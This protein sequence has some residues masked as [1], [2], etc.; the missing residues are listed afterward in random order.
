MHSSEG[1]TQNARVIQSIFDFYVLPA[2]QME[3]SIWLDRDHHIHLGG[4]VPLEL[5]KEW[6]ENGLISDSQIL[7]DLHAAHFGQSISTKDALLKYRK[8][9]SLVEAYQAHYD[10]LEDF[11]TLFRA[12]APQEL[13]RAN[14]ARIMKSIAPRAD[15]RISVPKPQGDPD[16]WAQK[17]ITEFT[18][19]KQCLQPEQ[20]LVLQFQRQEFNNQLNRAHFNALTAALARQSV[21]Q[22]MFDFASKPV[23]V[24]DIV[25]LL[26]Q[27]RT[28][29]PKAY[30]I[31]H[32]GELVSAFDLADRVEDVELLLPYV[33]RIGH[34]ICL[35]V[36][37]GE[38]G[39]RACQILRSM[40]QRK[41][42]IEVNPTSNITLGGA[43]NLNYVHRFVQCGVDL[44][45]GTDDPGF[46]ATDLDKERDMLRAVLR[47]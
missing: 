25:E 47:S 36:A 29:L 7:I 35:G 45:L 21:I 44:Y 41:I 30:I 23:R 15:I 39:E 13:V 34:A 32:H 27:I 6:A 20:N 37:E 22:P 16:E 43:P 24:P 2:C 1:Q 33:D 26:R 19:Y 18:Y 38:L 4:A 17:T 5:V 11:L 12:Y 28:D 40:A 31:Y 10:T 14:A 9:L 8:G 3:P 42:G 46:L